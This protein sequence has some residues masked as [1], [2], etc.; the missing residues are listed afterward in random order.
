MTVTQQM[1]LDLAPLT[2][3]DYADHLTL[4]DKF[5]AFHQANPHVA[6][7]LEALADQWLTSHARVGTKAL[8]ERLRW[9]SGIQTHGS[10]WRL[11]NSWTAFYSRL[12]LERRPEWVGRIQLREQRAA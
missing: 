3:P 2:E 8:I 10:E 11:N 1:S 7:A 4:A 5:A 9:E 12:L 6:D